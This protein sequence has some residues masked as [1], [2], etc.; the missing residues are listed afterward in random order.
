MIA[1]PKNYLTKQ[2]TLAH[3]IILVTGAEQG[4]GRAIS[5]DLARSGARVIL[6]GRDMLALEKLYDKIIH[7]NYPEPVIHAFDFIG[8][9]EKHYLEIGLAIKKEFSKLDGIVHNA[10]TL[11]VLTSIEQYDT[12]TWYETMQTNLNAPFML[13]KY[14][15]PLL[16]KSKDARILF[17][18]DNISI[19]PDAYWGAYGVSKSGLN[20]FAQVLTQ[21]LNYSTIKVNIFI[22]PAM[23]TNLRAHSHPA[24]NKNKIA[25]VEKISPA[26]V[27]LMSAQSQHL[28]GEKLKVA[29]ENTDSK[30]IL[31][32]IL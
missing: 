9:K 32:N 22:P 16:K 30:N 20:A 6:L 17:I 14:C 4:F 8:A 5:L 13:T 19:K 26:I 12:K 18:S 23:H 2:E 11:G 27:Y 28:N 10:A 3:K 24:E 1:I 31:I 15:L 7:C 21:E 25:R 29:K